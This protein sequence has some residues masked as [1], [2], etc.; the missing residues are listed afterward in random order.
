MIYKIFLIHSFNYCRILWE[1]DSCK[2]KK[3][4]FEVGLSGSKI[5]LDQKEKESLLT[6]GF[7]LLKKIQFQIP[8]EPPFTFTWRLASH[9]A[10]MT[11]SA[12][13]A[14]DRAAEID[15]NQSES[16]PSRVDSLL[17]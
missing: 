6:Y 12:A 2:Y 10:G 11:S 1:D 16:N 14:A 15:N 5:I 7:Q 8:N 3:K 13:S 17:A 4:Y 9:P